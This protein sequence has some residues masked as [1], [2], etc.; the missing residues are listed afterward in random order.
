MSVLRS[1]VGVRRE[2]L[3]RLR[4][5]F[6]TRPSGLRGEEF[7]AVVAATAVVTTVASETTRSP[8][9]LNMGDGGRW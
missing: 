2:A 8:P 3:E 4:A 6:E 9:A 5:G 7:A 1:V